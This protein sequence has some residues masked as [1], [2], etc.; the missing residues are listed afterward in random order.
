MKNDKN[1]ILNC[2]FVN[3]IVTYLTRQVPSIIIGG[4]K[5]ILSLWSA[6]EKRLGHLGNLSHPG[7]QLTY[8]SPI[9]NKR[10]N[11]NLYT[12]III[13]ILYH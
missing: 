5:G 4:T 3:C 12:K 6:E 10:I 8:Y 7:A 11:L 1:K 13:I 2:K 9:L